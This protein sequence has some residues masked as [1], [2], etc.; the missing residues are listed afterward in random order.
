MVETPLSHAHW[1]WTLADLESFP[2]DGNRYEI[3]DGSLLVSPAPTPRHQKITFLLNRILDDAAPDYL[4]VIPAAGV[5]GD[6]VGS[7]YLIPDL[8]V[9]RAEA[10]TQAAKNFRPID[11]LLAVEV[12]P[13][14][15]IANDKIVKR[16]AYA[17]LGIPNYW[18]VESDAPWSILALRLDPSGAYV[19]AAEA[20]GDDELVVDQPFPVRIIP[21][22]LRR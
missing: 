20:A 1:S 7:R 4:D 11:V 22:A 5:L 19:T 10:I 17:S 14:S 2:D 12:T 13:P 15:T 8:L 6:A 3:I 16:D 9:V 21:A 18:L